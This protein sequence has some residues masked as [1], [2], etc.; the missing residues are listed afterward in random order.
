MALVE[1]FCGGFGEK[2]LPRI[3]IMGVFLAFVFKTKVLFVACRK[4]Y[5][6]P[7]ANASYIL[8]L[9]GVGWSLA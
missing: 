8:L 2:W 3:G 1:V 7:K 4:D 5:C 9:P 6:L